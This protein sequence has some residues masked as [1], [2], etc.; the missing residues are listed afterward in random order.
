MLEAS[1]IEDALSILDLASKGGDGGVAREL[2]S[3]GFDLV[4]WY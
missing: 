2:L 4:D 3:K 1:N